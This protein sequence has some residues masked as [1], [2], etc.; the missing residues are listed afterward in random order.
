MKSAT[1]STERSSKVDY[2]DHERYI[3]LTNLL[4]PSV[5]LIGNSIVAG[6]SRYQSVCKKFY[7]LFS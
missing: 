5:L 4:Q 1:I 2:E 3:Y 6:L 7:L